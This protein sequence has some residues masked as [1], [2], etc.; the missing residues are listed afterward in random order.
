MEN[1]EES[2]EVISQ[3]RVDKALVRSNFFIDIYGR[4]CSKCG[5]YKTWKE[6]TKSNKSGTLHGASC[7]DCEKVYRADNKERLQIASALYREK[8]REEINRK[9]RTHH[10]ANKE[11]LNAISKKYYQ[12]HKEEQKQYHKKY[13]E[14]NS[15]II[16][17]NKKVYRDNNK[18]KIREQK[19]ASRKRNEES[20]KAKRQ[21]QEYKDN[22]NS[23][24]RERYAKDQNYKI[25]QILRSRFRSALK[26]QNTD[27]GNHATDLLGCTIAYFKKYIENL[28]EEGMSWDNHKLDGW[29]IDHIIGVANFD[30]TDPEQQKKCFHYTNMQPLWAEENMCK[31]SKII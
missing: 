4:E 26:A 14:E 28:W 8:N 15:E 1:N 22:R 6:F 20:I 24:R 21:T 13:R 27:K 25:E 29:H 3:E 16:K 9:K 31:G 7:R 19:K 30:L 5:K 17:I 11:R 23:R 12:E 2:Q 10:H 18:E